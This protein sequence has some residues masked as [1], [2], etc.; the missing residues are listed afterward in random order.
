MQVFTYMAPLIVLPYLSRVLGTEGF[1]LMIAALGLIVLANVVTD[2][3]FDLSATYLISRKQNKK[4][5][6]SQV[7]S[8]IYSLKMLILIFVFLVVF[9]YL[10]VVVSYSNLAI[11][12]IYITIFFQA[13]MSP[14]LFQGIEKMKLITYVTIFSRIVYVVVLMFLVKDSDDYD[15]A[16]VCNAIAIML[17]CILSNWLIKK[18]GFY[19]V[20]PTK[21][22]L[23]FV[24]KHSSQF[25]LS[26]LALQASSSISILVLNLYVSSAKV[27]LYGASDKLFTAFKALVN[28]LSQAL[29]PYMAN[30]GNATLLFKLTL[31][32]GF[33]LMVP[34]VI[35]FYFAED[36]LL[37]FYGRDFVEAADVL[38][39]FI[40]SGFLSFFSILYGYPAFASIKRVELANKSVLVGGGGQ[41]FLL[42]ILILFDFITIL[43]ISYTVLISLVVILY[44]RITWFLKYGSK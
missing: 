11:L 30:T 15:L 10:I 41:I 17:A 21:R 40:I 31:V 14:W 43:N 37:V 32:L 1:G 8:A 29:Y 22:M 18:E 27:G 35:A 39:V 5:Y 3:G 16:L 28:P 26:R 25:F 13:F 33:I 42:S 34:A 12:A 19:F 23:L 4:H 9:V 24:L 6:I 2:F 38:R 44:L 36:I 20:F 7:L